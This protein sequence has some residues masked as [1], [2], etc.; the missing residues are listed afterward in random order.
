LAS[1]PLTHH[2]PTCFCF[3][4]AYY[5]Y[6]TRSSAAAREPFSCSSKERARGEGPPPQKR[7]K[8]Q[9]Q[10]T[11]DNRP[12]LL[13]FFFFFLSALC[14]AA[15]DMPPGGMLAPAAGYGV[16]LDERVPSDDPFMWCLCETVLF[17]G[18]FFMFPNGHF[19]SPKVHMKSV[20]STTTTPVQS[21]K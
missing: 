8:K 9:S 7:D 17:G 2:G 11:T 1:D 10:K 4:A 16:F 15:V 21:T 18:H 19:V 5:R 14:V 13:P 6:R 12:T 20:T 3:L